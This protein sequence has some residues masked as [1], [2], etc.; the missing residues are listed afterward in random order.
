[1][2]L[3]SLSLSS[4]LYSSS[5]VNAEWWSMLRSEQSSA[6]R[7]MLANRFFRA[8]RTSMTVLSIVFYLVYVRNVPVDRVGTGIFLTTVIGLFIGLIGTVFWGKF[9]GGKNQNKEFSV[10]PRWYMIILTI[11]SEIFQFIL[12]STWG[13]PVER[14]EVGTSLPFVG[15]VSVGIL[16]NCVYGNWNA[17]ANGW[18][19]D[20]DCQLTAKATGK[21]P[22]R[23]KAT[24]YYFFSFFFF[25]FLTFFFSSP[26]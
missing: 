11:I 18:A 25:F 16:F 2:C 13:G 23:K 8:T 1:M 14:N 21:P 5:P 19:V 24:L 9:F 26:S 7:W 15:S 3:L 10:D 20:E 22:V 4:H 17:S 6:I 12:L